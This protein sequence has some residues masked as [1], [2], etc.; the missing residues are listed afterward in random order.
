MRSI[1]KLAL[2]LLMAVGSVVL[3]LGLPVLWLWIG[4]LIQS[5]SQQPGFTPYIVVL[6][7]LVVSMAAFGRLLSRTNHLYEQVTGTVPEVRVRMPWHRSMRG[8]DDSRP[9]RRVLD[10]VMVASVSMA[11]FLFGMWFFFFAGSSL[12]GN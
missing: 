4:S 3:W 11:V 8:D 6:V 5:G 10:V 1:A 12:P 7:G 9:P 2:I